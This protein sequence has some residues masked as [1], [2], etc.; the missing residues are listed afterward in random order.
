MLGKI[1][2]RM[3]KLPGYV[4]RDERRDRFERV[5]K[6]LLQAR[7]GALHPSQFL[8]SKEQWMAQLDSLLES[9]DT[10]A[11]ARRKRLLKRLRWK[12]ETTRSLRS[13]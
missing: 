3:K 1:T 13:P 6:Q 5:Q 4:G 2:D 10:G 7:S 8:M 9:L 11:P 12:N